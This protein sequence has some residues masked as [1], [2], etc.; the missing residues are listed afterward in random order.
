MQEWN[1]ELPFNLCAAIVE[2]L[3]SKLN[4]LR[5]VAAK[6]IFKSTSSNKYEGNAWHGE[7]QRFYTSIQLHYNGLQKCKV[8]QNQLD[9]HLLRTFCTDLAHLLIEVAASQLFIKLA[10]EKI[11]T[12][13]QRNAALKKLQSNSNVFKTLT[14]LCDS[15][16]KSTQTFLDA[17]EKTADTLS[18]P[19]KPLDKKEER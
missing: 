12:V 6:A 1:N 16:T 19:A 10:D 17:F 2:E 3:N 11:E 14:S 18:I 7:V 8:D 15:L 13:K 5:E 4:E 9:K